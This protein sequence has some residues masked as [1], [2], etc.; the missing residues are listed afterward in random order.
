MPLFQQSNSASG[1]GSLSTTFRGNG[2]GDLLIAC[3]KSALFGNPISVSDSMGNTWR[4]AAYIDNYTDGW[5][6]EMFYVQNCSFTL[7]TNTV[8]AIELGGAAMVLLI[9]E[10]S[11]LAL[12]SPL[13]AEVSSSGSGTAL[14][15]GNLVCNKTDLL[16]GFGYSSGGDLAAGSGFTNRVTNS[17]MMLEGQQTIIS[18]NAAVFTAPTGNWGVIAAS[19][20]TPPFVFG[21][22]T[23]ALSSPYFTSLAIKQALTFGLALGPTGAPTPVGGMLQGAVVGVAYSEAISVNGGSSPFTFSVKSGSFPPG[24]ALAV[25]TGVISG[26][27]TAAGTF[28]FAVAVTDGASNSVSSTFTIAIAA[29]AGSSGNYG[30]IQ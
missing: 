20:Y 12:S 22:P 10:Y 2:A 14:S 1:I 16:I 25:S 28:T 21:D 24:L 11:G 7:A 17:N 13:S 30:W 29:G 18:P 3:V 8:T 23:A 4:N 26:T 15:S 27:P 6:M 9:A 5:R 19:F